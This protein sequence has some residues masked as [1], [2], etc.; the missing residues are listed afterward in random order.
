MLERVH[1]YD[2][3]AGVE[4][5]YG[6]FATDNLA[7]RAP[8][9]APSSMPTWEGWAQTQAMFKRD[10]AQ[11]RNWHKDAVARALHAGFDIIYV[12][13]GHGY[14]PAQ[15]LSPVFNQRADEYGDS[16]ENRARL[17]KELC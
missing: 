16:F 11:F 4:L 12:Y 7:T 9:M 14:M 13:A 3:L 6:G 1:A 15:F 10:L 2:A 5:W 17:I 8:S